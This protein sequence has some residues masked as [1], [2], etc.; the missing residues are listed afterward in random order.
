MASDYATPTAS[1]DQ[2]QVDRDIADLT[3]GAAGWAALDLPGRIAL[4]TRTRAAIADAADAWTRAAVAAKSTPAGPWEGEEWLSGPYAAL[5]GFAAVIDSL[6]KLS[7]GRSPAHGLKAGT[8]PGGR[9]TFTVLPS[10]LYEFNLF[11]GFRGELW[12]SPGVSAQQAVAAAGLGARRSGENGGVGLVL[13]A[14]N[15]SSIGPLDVLYELIAHNRASVLKLNPTF[16][17]LSD[18][19]AA[20]FGPLFDAGLL[21]IINGGPEIG[22]YLTGHPGIRHV[23]ITGAQRTHDLIVWGT[24]SDKPSTPKLDKPITSELGGVSPIIVVPGRWS[25]ADLKFQAEHVATQ[26]LHNAG[27]NCIAG[28]ALI[29]SADWDQKDQFLAALRDVLTS[30]PA[31]PAWYP[32][33]GAKLDAATGRYPAAERIGDR[34]LIE[35]TP[36]TAQ[37]LFTTE[38]FA[39]VLGY[40][41][42]PGTGAEFFGNAV[43]FANNSLYGTLGASIIVAPGDRRAMGAA[44][45]DALAQLHY[46]T[47]GVNVWSAIGF[48]VPGLSWG[49]Y[50]GNT[51]DNVGS[52]IGIVHNAHLLDNIERS[53]IYGPFRPFPRSVLGGELALSPKPSWFVTN[54]TAARVSELLTKFSAQPSW[55]KLPAIFSEA[56]RG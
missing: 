32:G 38:Y 6:E 3:A 23:H 19:Y 9:T 41:S 13:G 5:S 42:L 49:A 52:G 18:V 47:I 10:N 4:L 31:R 12:L 24:E 51:L 33:S 46:G 30:L 34:V 17:T 45:D 26:R 53:V 27:H 22:A 39:P 44:F 40:T 56:F 20:A 15:I 29:L 16:S 1:I 43:E 8:A 14:G 11:N 50:P 37:D 54:K 2:A 25:A 21:R 28:Q 48:L 7:Q 36:D 35:V 55:A